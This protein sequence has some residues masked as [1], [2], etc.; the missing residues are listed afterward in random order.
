[1]AGEHARAATNGHQG[2]RT[3]NFGWART[4]RNSKGKSPWEQGKQGQRRQDAMAD[5]GSARPTEGPRE[6]PWKLG[7][8]RDTV[9]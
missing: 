7:R 4:G 9:R 3:G 1:M 5:E 2:A 6:Q 8:S